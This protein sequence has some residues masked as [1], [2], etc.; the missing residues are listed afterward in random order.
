LEKSKYL[1]LFETLLFQLAGSSLLI[2][3]NVP[4]VLASTLSA[5]THAKRVFA[6]L[7]IPAVPLIICPPRPLTKSLSARARLVRAAQLLPYAV[8]HVGTLLGL[9]LELT[10]A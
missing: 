7:I 3:R 10:D 8:P 4:D 2:L 6:V 1:E 5:D 9:P